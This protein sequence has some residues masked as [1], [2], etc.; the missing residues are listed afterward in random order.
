MIKSIVITPL[1]SHKLVMCEAIGVG[2]IFGLAIDPTVLAAAVVT[3]ITALT[4]ATVIIINALTSAKKELLERADSV[5]RK[6]IE[7]GKVDA[8][9]LAAKV[10]STET[11]L[12]AM[13]KTGEASAIKVDGNLSAVQAQLAV[14][15]AHSKSLEDT[16]TTLTDILK[17]QKGAR[18]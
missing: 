15:S 2:L 8:D 6:A 9:A 5:E 11:K 3:V 12:D 10:A 16:I 14:A 13:K 4:G 7:A 18:L 1:L 17:A